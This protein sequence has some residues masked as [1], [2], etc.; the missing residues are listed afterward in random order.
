MWV[1]QANKRTALVV[2]DVD[3]RGG[4]TDVVSGK[5]SMRNLWTLPSVLP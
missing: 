3:Y 2:V 5:R 1:H 4:Y